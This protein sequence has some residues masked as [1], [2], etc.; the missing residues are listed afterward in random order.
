MESLNENKTIFDDFYTEFPNLTVTEIRNSLAAFMF[1]GDDVFKE[2]SMLSGGEKVRLAL[3]KILKTG[4][5]LLILDEP[6]N[7][8]DIVG[9]ESLEMLLKEYDGTIIFVSHDRYF[10]NKV[11]DCLLVFENGKV[12]YYEYGYDEYI[13]KREQYVEEIEEKIQEKKE[14][15]KKYNPLKEKQKL[16]KAIAKLEN[17]ITNLECEKA[18]LEQELGK[19]EVY[20]DYGKAMEV[21]EKLDEIKLKIEEA[22][23]KWEELLLQNE[24][25]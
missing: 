21:Q 25:E 2:I 5:N 14:K 9:K 1:Y 12:Q 20:T 10:V 7:H 8:M 23:N 17:E 11:S 19:E 18:S 15:G 13:E 6:T 22:T 16:E 4:P 3:C 24:C